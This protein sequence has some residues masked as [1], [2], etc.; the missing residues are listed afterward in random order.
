MAAYHTDEHKMQMPAAQAAGRWATSRSTNDQEMILKLANEYFSLAERELLQ[1]LLGTSTLTFD[2][3][4][5]QNL[6]LRSE[7]K[8]L[9]GITEKPQQTPTRGYLQFYDFCLTIDACKNIMRGIY[10]QLNSRTI[11][12]DNLAQF[13][14]QVMYPDMIPPE[15][16]DE[17]L[18][19]KAT[20][21]TDQWY[22]DY[23][24]LTSDRYWNV[25]QAPPG[26]SAKTND[27]RAYEEAYLL[28]NMLANT[29]QSLAQGLFRIYTVEASPLHC[30]AVEDLNDIHIYP[31]NEFRRDNNILPAREWIH[32]YV[33]HLDRLTESNWIN[34]FKNARSF[35]RENAA[36]QHAIYAD[37]QHNIVELFQPKTTG[38]ANYDLTLSPYRYVHGAF[39]PPIS[40]RVFGP[41]NPQLDHTMPLIGG[42]IPKYLKWYHHAAINNQIV[43]PTLEI[44]PQMISV[45]CTYMSH[46]PIHAIY[47]LSQAYQR[48]G[49]FKQ[50]IDM[51][52]QL[53]RSLEG[54]RYALNLEGSTTNHMFGMDDL[55]SVT[56]SGVVP[57]C[58]N[59]LVP[60]FYRERNVEGNTVFEPIAE[61]EAFNVRDGKVELASH[62]SR[63][64]WD[65]VPRV[66]IAEIA[67]R[68]TSQDLEYRPMVIGAGSEVITRL[69]EPQQR[70]AS[71]IRRAVESRGGFVSVNAPAESRISGE[72]E[73]Y[74]IPRELL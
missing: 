64:K 18:G 16:R 44:T 66:T 33:Y 5:A 4:E 3:N 55:P 40:P 32:P 68:N 17:V 42:A 46:H 39:N 28:D 2:G 10:A 60:Q 50:M 23:Y 53:Q 70:P 69:P 36:L 67:R 56:R 51:Y 34:T 71:E 38:V 48:S 20:N 59:G 21:V 72:M 65:C 6:I 7:R 12:K 9:M 13:E 43:I 41:D 8:L 30:D 54:A 26:P 1:K 11:N 61:S 63:Q 29:L 73:A 58:G 27:M 25:G 52:L 47:E 74:L 37:S 49:L 14:R 24:S 31:V 19:H 15:I 57:S 22:K 45:R 35:Y 62:V